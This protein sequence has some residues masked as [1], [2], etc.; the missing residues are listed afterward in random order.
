MVGTLAPSP[1]QEL[2]FGSRGPVISS[3]ATAPAPERQAAPGLVEPLPDPGRAGQSLPEPGIWSWE[4]KGPRPMVW[5]GG[6]AQGYLL[7]HQEGLAKQ[8]WLCFPKQ[9]SRGSWPESVARWTPRDGGA[10]GETCPRFLPCLIPLAQLSPDPAT[11]PGPGA[12]AAR[13]SLTGAGPFEVPLEK[14]MNVSAPPLKRR[15]CPQRSF[16]G[17]FRESSQTR[18]PGLCA[19]WGR[20]RLNGLACHCVLVAL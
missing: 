4:K 10:P 20:P 5:A 19:T 17:S 1:L 9:A 14:L 6:A 2:P 16:A 12:L 8:V 7:P 18:N 13:F 11:T 3:S 15:T